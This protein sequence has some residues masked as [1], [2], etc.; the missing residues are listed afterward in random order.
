MNLLE[1][2]ETKPLAILADDSGRRSRAGEAMDLAR[3]LK[4]LNSSPS[5]FASAHHPAPQVARPSRAPT[6]NPSPRGRGDAR[7]HT[8]RT[9]PRPRP[10]RRLRRARR[11]ALRRPRRRGRCCAGRSTG[12][13]RRRAREGARLTRGFDAPAR[14]DGALDSLDRRAARARASAGQGRRGRARARALRARRAESAGRRAARGPARRARGATVTRCVAA[15]GGVRACGARTR[16]RASNGAHARARRGGAAAAAP[17]ARARARA[18]GA[19][20]RARRARA[21]RARA[22]A[23]S[24]GRSPRGGSRGGTRASSSRCAGRGR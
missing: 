15:G 5:H 10:R 8:P 19:R 6:F 23:R 7:S 2:G 24:S 13:G 3:A 4:A 16:A 17:V 14:A 18:R 22:R 21:A 9:G 20:V 11:R 1:H 12:C